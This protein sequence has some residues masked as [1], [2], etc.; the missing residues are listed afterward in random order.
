LR[1]AYYV[2][3]STMLIETDLTVTVV[4]V[5]IVAKREFVEI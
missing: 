4:I 2:G 1:Y 3:G 5:S